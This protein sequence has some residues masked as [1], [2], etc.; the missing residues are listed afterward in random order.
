MVV[1]LF[2]AG[3]FTGAACAG[4]PGDILG[5]RNTILIGAIVF[6]VGGIVQTS[7]QSM[8][9]LYAGR[10]FA[11]VG[12]GFLTMMIPLYQSELS[13]PSIRGRVTALQQFML[14][15]GALVAS[16]TAWGTFIHFPYTS[17]K[18]WRIPLGIQIIPAAILA[19]L[20][21][22]FPES[23]RWLIQHGKPEEGLKNL[24]KL[25]AYGN[26]NDPWVRAEYEQIQESI[27]YDQEHEAKSYKELFTSM[28]AF[29]RLLLCV[30]LQASIQMT[31]VSA[32]QYYSTIIFVSSYSCPPSKLH[33]LDPD[34]DPYVGQNW[35]Q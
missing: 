27:A 19:A 16:W 21:L 15:I 3:A 28:P 30:A 13:H 11:G 18:Q 6:C 9:G 12:V 17:S 8:N 1:S 14:G 4:P 20:I 33:I 34:S 2:T 23:P 26:E 31:G 22:L 7:A 10:F 32:I 29:R 5:R 35:Y 25:H 24:A